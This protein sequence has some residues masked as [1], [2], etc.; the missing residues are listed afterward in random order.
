MKQAGPRGTE[1]NRNRETRW[2]L[3]SQQLILIRLP[4]FLQRLPKGTVSTPPSPPPQFSPLP[5][6][7]LHFL[8]SKPG[9]RRG[10]FTHQPHC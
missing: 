7:K 9:G 6:A 1:R 8:A 4:I 10:L 3:E 5:T 2:S